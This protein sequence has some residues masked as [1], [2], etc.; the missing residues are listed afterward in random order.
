MAEVTAALV[1]ELRE[2]TQAGMMDCKKAL[3]ENN[4]DMDKAIEYLREKGLAAANKKAGRIA[5]EG[6]VDSYIHMGGKVGVMVEI[7]C[8]TDFVG[9]TDT[10]KSLCHDVAM[11]IAAAAPEYVSKEEIPA[12]KIEEERRI[13]YEQIMNDEKNAKKPAA[14]IEKIVEGRVEKYCKEICL[15]D[16]PF[17]K[18]PDITIAQLLQEATLATGE[19]TT[20]RRF[21]RYQLGEGIEKKQSDLAAEIAEMTAKKA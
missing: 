11:H 17:V 7:N 12:E 14:I 10:F 6:A 2:R 8:E 3:V 1:K 16:Q 15:L 4:G 9:K 21:V 5:A 19:K 18:N 13:A 20:I